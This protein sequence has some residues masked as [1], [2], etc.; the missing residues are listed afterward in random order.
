MTGDSRSPS[1]RSRANEVKRRVYAEEA[2]GPPIP[3]REVKASAIARRA[4]LVCSTSGVQPTAPPL[5]ASK[6]AGH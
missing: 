5:T 6:A 4:G 3:G 2:P 1:Q